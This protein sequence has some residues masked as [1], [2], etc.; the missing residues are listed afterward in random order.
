MGR[1]RSSSRNDPRPRAALTGDRDRAGANAANLALRVRRVRRA[2]IPRIVALDERVT[3][4]AKPDYWQDV[5]ER[6]GRRRLGERM[7]LVAEPSGA[8]GPEQLLGFIVGEVRAWEFGSAPCGWV[9]ALSVEP[10]ARL[11]GTGQ[12]LLEALS[13]EFSKA[14]VG[15]MRTMVARDN[16][17]HLLF[18]RGEGM[19]AGPY[20]QLEKDLG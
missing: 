12:A 9:F 4:L 16:S 6:Y 18:F 11:R 5:F 8:E 10:R 17:L 13:D 19:V 20:I 2:D 3:G 7:F 15:K 1:P 14:G